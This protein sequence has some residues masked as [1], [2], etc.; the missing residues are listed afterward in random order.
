[1]AIERSTRPRIGLVL[2]SGGLR[3]AAH[4]GVIRQ[5][6]RHAIPIDV[7]VGVSAGAIIAAYFAAVGLTVDEMIGEAPAFRGRH[8]L[9]WGVTLRAHRSLKPVLRRFC[10]VIP[11]R[12]AQLEAACFEHLHHGVSRLGVVCH[13]LE[14]NLPEYF[15]TACTRGV[16]LADVAKASAALPGALP[17][18]ELLIEGRR[19]RLVDGG[20]S[21]GLPI[22]FA[23][24]PGLDATHLIVS[25]CRFKSTPAAGGKL[26]YIRPAMDEVHSFRA[27]R[28]T[29]MAAV[30]AGEAAVTSQSVDMIRGWLKAPVHPVEPDLCAAPLPG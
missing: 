19:C 5:L 28:A 26:I 6:Q 4:L 23:G 1:M 9:M 30:R 12:L 16:R 10:G 27:P 24:A 8:I 14:T 7:I 3:G 22:E 29:L 18:R 25:D 11:T 13:D 21:D 15:S 17:P 2:S 20:V